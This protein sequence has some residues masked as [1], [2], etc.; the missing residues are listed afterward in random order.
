MKKTLVKVQTEL[1]IQ[2]NWEGCP[3]EE[4]AFLKNKHVHKMFVTVEIGVEHNDRQCE[5]FVL[6][7]DVLK[8]LEGLYPVTLTV[9][10]HEIGS[11]SME[12][13]AH[14]LFDYLEEFGYPA[15]FAVECSEDNIFS[16]RVERKERR[17]KQ[18]V[19]GGIG[20]GI[21]I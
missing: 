3:L 5:F 1:Y 21:A 16:S 15:I 17:K 6:R 19:G 4:V 8:A 2:H 9:R 12:M 13:V 18:G 14:E 20:T 11:H 10:I 7:A